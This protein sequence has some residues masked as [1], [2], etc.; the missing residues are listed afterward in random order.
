[1]STMYNQFES[2]NNRRICHMEN[3]KRELDAE[4]SDLK[5]P[6]QDDCID[7][8]REGDMLQTPFEVNGSCAPIDTDYS[9]NK[10]CYGYACDKGS[11]YHQPEKLNTYHNYLVL[12]DGGKAE[13]TK[14]HQ[15]FNNWTKRN[16]DTKQYINRA[17][18]QFAP[19]EP[20]PLVTMKPCV[21][22]HN[23]YGE[24]L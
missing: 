3:I 21:N 9:L 6:A 4:L 22:P 10:W 13:C 5:I 2:M 15:Y 19:V 17:P 20:I 18:T 14:N 16:N 24:S 8:R 23:Y 7:F 11:F 1:M 12:E